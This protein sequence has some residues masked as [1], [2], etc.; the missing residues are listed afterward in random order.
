MKLIMRYI[1]DK[2]INTINNI[3]YEKRERGEERGNYNHFDIRFKNRNEVNRTFVRGIL[4]NS[5]AHD[6]LVG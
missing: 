1:T 4:R 6:L 5:V 3:F 2:T